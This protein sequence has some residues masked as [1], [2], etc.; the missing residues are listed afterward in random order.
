MPHHVAALLPRTDPDAAEAFLARLGFTR[1]SPGP[2]DNRILADGRGG[3][4]HLAWAVARWLVPG[5]NPFGLTLYREDAT[6]A[7]AP[8]AIGGGPGD[9]P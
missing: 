5:R 2:D 1:L 8:K 9:K 7:S 4:V 3:T 6:A